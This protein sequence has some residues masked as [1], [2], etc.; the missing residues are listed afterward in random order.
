[1]Q[2]IFESYIEKRSTSCVWGVGLEL[3]EKWLCVETNEEQLRR[4]RQLLEVFID[5]FLLKSTLSL[6][7]ER[8]N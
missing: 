1:M 6:R 3:G 2:T 5:L 7:R 4:P 8:F